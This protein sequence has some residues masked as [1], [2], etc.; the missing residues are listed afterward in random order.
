[1]KSLLLIS[2]SA[3]ATSS[4]TKL[5]RMMADTFADS[6]RMEVMDGLWELPLYT[7]ERELAGIPDVV[8]NLREKVKRAD[9]VLIST[10]EYLHN[11]PAVLKNA[12][13]WM[14]TSGE[15][16]EKPV[17]AITLTPRAPRGENAMRSLLQSLVAS[18]AR[19]LAELPIH[20][21]ELAIGDERGKAMDDDHRSLLQEA[22]ALL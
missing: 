18:K 22:I 10:P 12:L 8:K 5:L 9:A 2:G 16:S 17:L 15:L 7:H 19:V 11:I 14:T 20:L 4:N 3:S 1:M 6:Y 21:D 13:E